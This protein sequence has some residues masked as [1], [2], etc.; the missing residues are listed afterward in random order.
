[1]LT[2]SKFR[3]VFFRFCYELY[4]LRCCSMLNMPQQDFIISFVCFSEFRCLLKTTPR[5]F[6]FPINGNFLKISIIEVRNVNI[7]FVEKSKVFVFLLLR[8]RF[9]CFALHS[10]HQRQFAKS[11]HRTQYYFT[12]ACFYIL[13]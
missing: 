11:R 8:M 4:F 10:V 3:Q 5:T 13:V 7:A 6:R 1:M 9:D 12:F 2:V